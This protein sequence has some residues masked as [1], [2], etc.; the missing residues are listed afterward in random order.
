M[1]L[2]YYE[3]MKKNG[4]HIK[5]RTLAPIFEFSETHSFIFF[6]EAKVQGISLTIED[7]CN[8]LMNLARASQ[9]FNR[10]MVVEDMVK[11]TNGPISPEDADNLHSVLDS[12]SSPSTI[13]THLAPLFSQRRRRIRCLKDED[14]C[15]HFYGKNPRVLSAITKAMGAFQK[16]KYD[17]VIDGANVGFYMRCSI[18]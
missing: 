17:T 14:L 10:S 13:I 5:R 4:V 18:R 8:I 11:N 3:M 2:K 9:D 7:Y 1:F 15:G 6:N 16:M 12:M